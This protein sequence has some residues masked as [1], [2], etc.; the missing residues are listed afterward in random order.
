MCFYA[1]AD[2]QLSQEIWVEG[3]HALSNP[4]YFEW[5]LCD[6]WQARVDVYHT[7]ASC[8]EPGHGMISRETRHTRQNQA[9]HKEAGLHEID[10]SSRHGLGLTLH[11]VSQENVAGFSCYIHSMNAIWRWQRVGCCGLHASKHMSHISAVLHLHALSG[12]CA[13]RGCL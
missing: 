3:V 5:D 13:R 8:V 10:R 4:M 11:G 7:A 2:E 12:A 9:A 6:T 1:D